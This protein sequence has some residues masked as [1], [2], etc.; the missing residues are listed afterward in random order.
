MCKASKLVIEV[1]L[2]WTDLDKQSSE[3]P[4]PAFDLILYDKLITILTARSTFT[5]PSR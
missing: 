2:E 3:R 5:K 4:S 1:V